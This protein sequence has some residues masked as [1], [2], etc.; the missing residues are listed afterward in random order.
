[1]LEL[2]L[3]S[4]TELNNNFELHL[5]YENHNFYNNVMSKYNNRLTKYDFNLMKK[6]NL[7]RDT[8]LNNVFRTNSSKENRKLKNKK[9]KNLNIINN[10]TQYA[11]KKEVSPKLVDYLTND[12]CRRNNVNMSQLIQ[13]LHTFKNEQ[14]LNL[15]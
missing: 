10:M 11:I 8:H 5:D 14:M 3:S 9:N 15:T 13:E 2:I 1:M 4:G 6:Y 7:D 12:Y